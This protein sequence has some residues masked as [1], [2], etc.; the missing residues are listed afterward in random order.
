MNEHLTAPDNDLMASFDALEPAI[1]KDN[2]GSLTRRLVRWFRQA[3]LD[4]RQAEVRCTDFEE[5]EM[6]RTTCE[7]LVTSA[8]VLVAS[9]NK[10][11]EAEL[12]V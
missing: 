11:H 9:W 2:D 5:K 10:L 1:T 4:C 3:E 6:L 12:A 8:R 7:A